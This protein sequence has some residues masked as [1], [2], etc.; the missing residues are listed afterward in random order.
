MPALTQS[1][2]PEKL[3]RHGFLGVLADHR[4]IL[5]RGDVVARHPVVVGLDVE[6]SGEF[7]DAGEAATSTHGNGVWLGGVALE[8]C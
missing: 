4:D 2:A 3:L 8:T 6:A 5:R 1:V 7:I